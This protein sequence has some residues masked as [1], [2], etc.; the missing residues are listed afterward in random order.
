MELEDLTDSENLGSG[1]TNSGGSW[2]DDLLDTGGDLLGGAWDWLTDDDGGV[3]TGG[4]GLGSLLGGGLAAYLANQQDAPAPT[5]YQGGIPEYQYTR[6]MIQQPNDPNRRPGSGG[7]RY[8][9]DGQFIPKEGAPAQNGIAT[10]P[11]NLA[12]GGIAELKSPRY[13]RGGTDGMA[14]K[15]NTAIDGKDPAALSHGEFVIPA[16]VVSHLG[17][18]NS[19]AGAKVL[20]QMMTKVRKERT[21]NPKQ[22]KQID[23]NQMVPR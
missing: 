15:I 2:F 17:N 6:H 3:S 22:G 14:D 19:E 20:E 7:R 5:G 21:G 8:F 16:D 4:L 11:Q 9:T 23:P 18:G 1:P 13:L 10:V 12:S